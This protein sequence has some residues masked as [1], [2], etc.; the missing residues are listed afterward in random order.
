[1][2]P[3]SRFNYAS[4]RN[5]AKVLAANREAKHASAVL[6]SD[7]DSYMISPC[8]ADKWLVIELCQEARAR[9]MPLRCACDADSLFLPSCRCCWTRWC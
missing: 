5:G 7:V 8:A 9:C 1:M 2:A 4:E 6:T 3:P